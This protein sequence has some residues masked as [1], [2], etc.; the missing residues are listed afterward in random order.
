MNIKFIIKNK[1]FNINFFFKFLLYYNIILLKTNIKLNTNL[2]FYFKF[3][4]KKNFNKNFLIFQKEPY[5]FINKKSKINF[6]NLLKDK[7]YNLIIENKNYKTLSF[8]KSN[9]NISNFNK[10]NNLFIINKGYSYN[11]LHK[12]ILKISKNFIN[13]NKLKASLS[14]KQKEIILNFNKF[15][16]KYK[17]LNNIY[18]INYIYINNLLKNLYSNT[19]YSKKGKDIT[20]GLQYIETIFESKNNNYNSLI[21]KKGYLI[22]KIFYNNYDLLNNYFI[23]KIIIFNNYYNYNF[24]FGISNNIKFLLIDYSSIIKGGDLIQ[25]ITYSPHLILNNKFL[26]LI[27]K[28]NQYISAKISLNFIQILIVESIYKQYIYNNINIPLIHFEIIT[29]KMT[30]W[31]KINFNGDT[32]FKLNDIISF[33][34][35]HL[36]NIALYKNNYKIAYYSPLIL[37]IS[38]SILASSGFLTAASFQEIIRVLIKSALENQIEWLINLKTKVI[39]SDLITTGT[40]WYRFFNKF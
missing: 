37:G 15:L 34:I 24:D 30:S 29:K 16:K 33:N 12:Y 40:G 20:S 4:L 36:I 13:S 9:L 14:P 22:N 8:I 38:K 35:L 31:V 25:Y 17:F 7:K 6:I 26:S 32:N 2:Y 27:N 5:E 39:L 10:I 3:I 21:I 23:N 11:I 19:L 1:F 18:N 28:L